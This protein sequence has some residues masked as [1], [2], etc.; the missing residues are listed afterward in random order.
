VEE[1]HPAIDGALSL[2]APTIAQDAG[3]LLRRMLDSRVQTAGGDPWRGSRLTGDGFPV[4]FSFSTADDR[5]R[6]TVE[7]GAPSLDPAH[8]IE[9]AMDILR[10]AG[11]PIPTGIARSFRSLQHTGALE[12]GAW[13]GCRVAEGG[14][15]FKLYAEVPEKTEPIPFFGPRLVLPD[16]TVTTRM[17]AYSPGTKAFETYARVPSLEPRHVP[18]LLAPAGLQHQAGEFLEFLVG[19]YG[20]SIRGR[21]P[22]PSVGVSYTTVGAET[23][24]VTLYLVARVLWGSDSRIRREFVRVATPQGWNADAYLRLTDP[25]ATREGWRTA[26]GLL[27]VTLDACTQS[28]SIGVRPVHA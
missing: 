20:F 2:F 10:H 19:A 3:R 25:I 12:Y 8:R 22:G 23:T 28:L 5:L 4:E 26:H 16:R 21:V 6:F 27:G 14:A 18:A 11:A 15:A 13:I 9:I 17:V 24:R 1:I 7:P